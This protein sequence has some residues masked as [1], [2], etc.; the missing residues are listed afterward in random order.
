M[1]RSSS[2]SGCGSGFC[3]SLSCH[4]DFRLRFPACSHH[5][6]T[7]CNIAAGVPLAGVGGLM[8]GWWLVCAARVAAGD[9]SRRARHPMQDQ[10]NSNNPGPAPRAAAQKSGLYVVNNARRLLVQVQIK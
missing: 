8:G 4:G 1:A 9:Q 3:L 6:R 10:R 2:S 7:K 5:D